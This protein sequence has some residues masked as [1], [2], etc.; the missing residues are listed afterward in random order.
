[1]IIYEIIIQD[2]LREAIAK[3][4]KLPGEEDA[5]TLVIR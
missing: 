5:L 3:F 4:Q 1:V 2:A